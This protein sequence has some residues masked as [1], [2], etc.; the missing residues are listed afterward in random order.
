MFENIVYKGHEDAT[1]GIYINQDTKKI[2]CFKVCFQFIPP[3]IQ[4]LT[5]GLNTV[6]DFEKYLK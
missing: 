2:K 4:S 5:N 1:E 3:D 6:S